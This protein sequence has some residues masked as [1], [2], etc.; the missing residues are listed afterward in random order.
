MITNYFKMSWRSLIRHHSVPLSPSGLKG[1]RSLG[2]V[3]ALLLMLMFVP[4]TMLGQSITN[5]SFST[6]TNGSLEDLTTGAT[7]LMTGSNDDVAT[8]ITPIGFDFNFMGVKYTHFSANSNGQVKLHQSAGETAIIGGNISSPTANTALLFPMA[9]DNEINGGIRCKIVGSKLVIEWTQF[10]AY[11]SD[12]TNAGNMQVWLGQ[13]GKIDYVY[14]E[15]YNSATFATSRSIGISSSNTATTAGYITLSASPTFTAAAS[16]TTNSFAAGANPIGSPLIANLGSSANGSRR[17]FS[18]TPTNFTI[19]DPTTLTFSNVY[20]TVTTVNWVDNSTNEQSFLVTK[21]TDAAFT[22]GVS[23]ILVSSTTGAGTGTA[24]TGVITGLIP[25]T[26]YYYKVTAVTE[27]SASGSLTGS[28]STTAPGNFVSIASG[29][30]NAASTWDAGM[31]PASLDNATISTGHT[32]TINATS[33]EIANLAVNGTL[34]YGSTP[35]LF[36]VS[37]N[38]TVNAGGL[39]NVFNGTT[40][41]TLNVA[42]NVVL[43][44]TIDLSIGATSEGT[45][46]LN[47]SSLQTVSGSGVFKSNIIR[48]LSFSNTAAVIPNINWSMPN[49]AVVY[50]LSFAGSKVNLG[51]NKI[52]FGTTAVGNSLTAPAGTGFMNGKF[53]RYWAATTSGTS[54]SAGSDPTGTAS[55]YPFISAT[56]ANRPMY[57]ARTSTTG[58]VAGEIAVVYNDATTSTTGLSIADGSYTVNQRYNA[59]WVVSN[60]GTAVSS[61]SYSIALLAENAFVAFNGNARIIGASAA[62]GG[63]HQNGTATPGAQRITVPQADLF[64]GPLYI[65]LA[66][67]DIPVTSVATG[68]WN[69]PATWSTGVVPGCNDT[70]I[71]SA[72]HTVTSDSAGNLSKGIIIASGATLIQ[73]AG[74][75]TVGCTLKNNTFANNGTF[76]MSGGTL[77]VN[78]NMVH[79]AGSTFN[80]SAGDIN[81]DGNDAGAVASS[82]ASGTHMLN[83]VA[84]AVVNLN[85]TGGNITIVDPPQSASTSTYAVRISQGGAFNN[86][87]GNHTFKFGN[88]VSND[89]STTGSNGFY[90]YTYS[91]VYNYGL[92]NVVVDAGTTGVNRFVKSNGTI[93]IK[94]D[95]TITSGEYKLESTHHI[96]GN[97]VNNGILTTTS[98]LTM[99]DYNGSSI[100][101][102]LPQSISGTGVFRNLATS[103]T[104][105][106][107]SFTINNSSAAGV[108]LNVPLSVSGTLT[109]TSGKVNTTATN[110]LTL[111]TATLAGSLSGGGVNSYINGPF[112]RTFATRTAT[113][114]YSTTTLFPVGKATSYLPIYIDPTTTGVVVMTGEAFDSNSGT[115]GGGVVTLGTNRWEALIK[116]G[117]TN[118]TS[119]FIRVVDAA[120]VATNKILQSPTANGAYASIL[121]ATTF[122]SGTPNTLT[123]ATAIVAANYTGYFSYGDLNICPAPT[124]QATSFMAGNLG[125]TAFSG[126]FT[127]AASAPSHYLVVRYTA[128]ATPTAPVNYTTYVAGGTLGTG[129]IAAVVAAPATAFNQTGLTA[130]TAYDYYVYAYNNVSCYGPSYNLT[131]PLMSTVTTC[132]TATVTP[133]AL[134]ATGVSSNGFTVAWTATA[135]DAIQLDIATNATFTAFVPGYNAKA[136]VAGTTSELVTGLSTNTAY[137][138]RV[139][140]ISGICYSANSSTLAVTTECLAEVAPTAV[141]TFADY[142]GNAPSPICWTERTG[143]LIANSVLT[144]ANSGWTSSTG[145]ANTGTNVAAMINLYGTKNDWLISNL[146]DLGTGP[147][148]LSYNM[149]VTSYNGT[150]AQST[151]ATHKVDVVIST[152]G[153]LT[154]SNANVLKTYTGVGTYSN[155]GQLE[156]INLNAYSGV[157][158]IA[159]VATTSSNSP[160]I[161]FHL[162]NFRVENILA[163]VISGFTSTASCGVSTVLTIVGTNFTGSTV[164]IGGTAVTPSSI[165]DTQ[166]VIPVSTAFNGNIVVTTAG[167]TATSATPFSF[168]I[169]PVLT[170]SANTAT[171][172][173]GSSTVVNVSAGAS[174]YDTYTW[175]PAVGVTGNVTSGFTFSATTSGVYTLTASQSAG[176]CSRTATFNLTVNPAP[177]AFTL[178]ASSPS[179]CEGDVVSLVATGGLLNQTL[180]N[181]T[182]TGSTTLPSSLTAVVGAGDTI[183]VVNA[184]TAGGTANQLVITG[185]SQTANVTNR[186]SAGPFNTSGFNSLTLSWRNFLSHYSSSYNY[187]VSIQTSTDGVTWQNTSWSTSPV[188]ATQAAS[189]Q[190]LT[191]TGASVGSPTFYIA[192]TAGGQTFGMNNW[193]IDDILLTASGTGN[194]I[195]AP[196]TDLYT[197]AAGT[198]AYT[199]TPATTVYVKGSSATPANYTATVTA[200]NTCSATASVGVAVN[201]NA[202][203]VAVSPQA[204]LTLANIVISPSTGIKWYASQADALAGT[205]ELPATTPAVNGITYY[206]THTATCESLPTPVTIDMSLG[207]PSF[208]MNTL[209]YY[210][211]PVTN[212]LTVS[213]G[214]EI[215]GL[216]LY[217]MVGQQLMV[218]T[219][220]STETQID[221]SHLPAG[222]YLL[223]VSSGSQSKMVKLLK[224]Q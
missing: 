155:T 62:I 145:F 79:N 204:A 45:F 64:A 153:G 99:G 134:V 77:N 216:K 158:K 126:S 220:N 97:V 19:V 107:A 91:G 130:G 156:L 192:F 42:G 217:N 29:N 88:G 31:V 218:K 152:D 205:P 35:T 110:I 51:G 128:G 129:T 17:F 211:N 212:V 124:D 222:S 161:H 166:I 131:T 10:Y 141:Q 111:G 68:N 167:G 182:F 160:D 221:M 168:S 48:N 200:T 120:T 136:L 34:A 219:V 72:G 33:L 13:N 213:Y 191:L 115:L 94:K 188:T 165:T 98:T 63:A 32:V 96:A 178:A 1:R 198:V 122:V 172:C 23:S 14:G 170:L 201:I 194:V 121:P 92:G 108:S 103:E 186:V 73:S 26:M 195:W 210:P 27:A 169:S 65:G 7:S 90:I 140:A 37:G 185:N 214:Q 8:T 174:D 18:F 89:A 101:N 60:E 87:T 180:L 83:V 157:I 54:I 184:V 25:S 55:R 113:G 183:A 143:A 208:D 20:S 175:S 173:G 15:I 56:G 71:I 43:N 86:A 24:Y 139:R 224:N 123:T 58:G 81:I 11:Y 132:A 49:V 3:F 127:A 163:P 176:S 69:A 16:F 93:P 144:V 148:K 66:S 102:A 21:A 44:G 138:V 36:A 104:A 206:A 74:D 147:K 177:S 75:L 76:T 6:G 135:T 22:T 112:A 187:N 39:V 125:S 109:L 189:V 181:E 50:N 142:T 118:F 162:D 4:M 12:L 207:S 202:A 41:K 197:N 150:T 203:P 133:T 151:L 84:N 82:V 40:G 9:G 95:L 30:W 114:T 179:V 193:N 209:K 119:S 67:S 2:G 5:Y 105:N 85:L 46:V 52:T 78:G 59:N 38:L 47:G 57:I 149:A 137:Y 199:G 154:W 164:T 223:E 100:V 28:V 196:V 146:I 215:T 70:A 116:S 53:S 61:G 171:I 80:Q 106:L 117:N 159:F 190:T